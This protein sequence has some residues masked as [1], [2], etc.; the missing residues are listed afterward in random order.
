[1]KPQKNHH[2]LLFLWWAIGILIKSI[3]CQNNPPPPPPLPPMLSPGC[4]HDLADNDFISVVT[5]AFRPAVQLCTS[6]FDTSWFSSGASKFRQTI[7]LGALRS[8]LPLPHWRWRQCRHWTENGEGKCFFVCRDKAA[9]CVYCHIKIYSD[10]YSALCHPPPGHEHDQVI[11]RNS[12]ELSTGQPGK[13]HKHMD[14][15]QMVNW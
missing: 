4:K 8:G 6:G 1:M 10:M 5:P 13:S 7:G 14:I 15:N 9:A 3:K 12:L 2:Q 11:N